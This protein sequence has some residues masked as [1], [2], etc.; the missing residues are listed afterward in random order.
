M[1]EEDLQ[2]EIGGECFAPG[3]FRALVVSEA[4]ADG[5]RGCHELRREREKWR[6]A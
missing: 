1:T 5:R 2:A 6:K 3:H 4:Q